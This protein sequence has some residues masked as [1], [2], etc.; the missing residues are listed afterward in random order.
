MRLKIFVFL[1]LVMLPVVAAVHAE[2]YKS[3]KFPPDNLIIKAIVS[4]YGD[5]VKFTF[6]K[7]VGKVSGEG[8]CHTVYYYGTLSGWGDNIYNSPVCKL[9]SNLWIVDGNKTILIE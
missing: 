5:S 4:S 2:P 1:I 8:V 9:D 6:D 7:F 3:K